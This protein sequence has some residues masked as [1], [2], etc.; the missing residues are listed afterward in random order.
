[1]AGKEAVVIIMDVGKTMGQELDN[2]VKL[3]IATEASKLLIQQKLLLT[4]S[5]EV[6]IILMGTEDTHNDLADQLGGYSNI[7]VL[8]ELDIPSLDSLTLLSAIETSSKKADLLDSIVVAITMIET[9]I[10]KKKYKKRLFILTDGNC[11]VD[12]SDQLQDIIDQINIQEIRVNVIALGFLDAAVKTKQQELTA[13][14]LKVLVD[15]V[16]GVMYPSSTAM[17][18]YK[19]FRKR[20]VYPVAKYKGPLD[21]G[22]GF[23]L[24]V[25]V[26]GKTKEEPLPSLKKHSTV[27]DF[28]SDCKEGLVKM[29]REVALEDDPSSTVIDSEDIIKA[30]FYGKSVVPVSVDD[31]EQL[32]YPCRKCMKVLG[33]LSSSAIPRHYF[34]SGVD[35]VLPLPD[36]AQEKAFAAFV[37]A[38]YQ[39]DDV[40]LVRYCTRDYMSVRLAVL[41][42]CIKPDFICLWLNYLPTSE[43]FRDFPFNDLAESSQDQ[44]AKTEAFI[45][46]L[47]L[48]KSEDSE[49]KLKP[50]SLF[51]PTLQ[52][53]YQCLTHRAEN[54]NSQLPPLDDKIEH[55]LRPDLE[56]F[57]NAENEC[58]AFLAAFTLKEVEVVTKEKKMYVDLLKGK[59]DEHEEDEGIR[60]IGEVDP[61]ADFERMV[62][63]R[64]VDRVNTAIQQM[65]DFVLKLLEKDY[66]GNLHRKAIEC[67]RALRRGCIEEDQPGDF[68]TFLAVRIK[69]LQLIYTDFWNFMVDQGV[70]LISSTE[71][72]ASRVSLNDAK[73]FLV[74]V[75]KDQVMSSVPDLDEIE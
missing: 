61:V 39:R 62:K 72:N 1:M 16:E 59:P 3:S 69:N 29:S 74:R 5:H 63:D 58:R 6:G 14:I 38:L 53:F 57:K 75:Q 71:S 24:N 17:Q 47:S 67:L 7:S 68:N 42:P 22:L 64:K 18:I 37:Q 10:G 66:K 2:R 41:T 44:Q 36:P 73:M 26:Y 52:Y 15:S 54:P 43:D 25:C 8:E 56:M 11:T 21:L 45:N 12:N 20:S 9:K 34:M 51:S 60:E 55:Y 65:E 48:D 28:S 33:Y 13:G 23:S 49:E 32:K 30:F 19:Q 50:S 46:A 40:V 27:V 31:E 35:I 70:T 4:K